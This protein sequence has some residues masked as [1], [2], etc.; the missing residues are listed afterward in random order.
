MMKEY[1]LDKLEEQGQSEQE[2]LN[3]MA[4]SPKSET[5]TEVDQ[6]G[7]HTTESTEKSSGSKLEE[8][9]IEEEIAQELQHTEFIRRKRFAKLRLSLFE[10]ERF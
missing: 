1:Q 4:Q 2:Q 10:H 8:D 6:S 7:E 3:E 5:H 9:D